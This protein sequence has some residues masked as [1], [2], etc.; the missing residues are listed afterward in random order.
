MFKKIWN[1]MKA[2]ATR[3]VEAVGAVVKGV[4]GGVGGLLL[5]AGVGVGCALAIAPATVAATIS[6]GPLDG[7]SALA[8]T[9]GGTVGLPLLGVVG[10]VG[11]LLWGL[12]E[13]GSFLVRGRGFDEANK[14]LGK[15]FEEH[16]PAPAATAD[17]RHRG[18][19][20][21]RAHAAAR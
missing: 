9:V 18:A 3:A 21:H 4:F 10:L 12:A 5:G 7:V 20:H 14:S 1:W 13:A 11:S 6:G 8:L 2:A 16:F 17:T 19:A 15:W